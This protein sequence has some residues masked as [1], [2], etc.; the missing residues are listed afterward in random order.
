MII[1]SSNG[2]IINTKEI[3]LH[4]DIL[5]EL[6]FNRPQ[7]HLVLSAIEC[8]ENGKRFAIN[9]LQVIGF[10]MTS[11]D[12]WGCSPH[13]FDFEYVI[14]SRQELIPRLFET[15]SMEND[16]ACQMIDRNLYIETKMIFTS[17]DH[18]IIACKSILI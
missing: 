14:P 6:T 12:F 9:F 1:D 16:P 7:K 13:I 17:G 15:K 11:C 5:D 18:L 8:K 2:N 3:Y 4:D 10:E